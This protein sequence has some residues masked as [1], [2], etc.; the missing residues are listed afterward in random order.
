LC[1]SGNSLSAFEG[2]LDPTGFRDQLWNVFRIKVNAPQL[3]ALMAH[4][5]GDAS[6]AV[7]GS[8]FKL[9]FCRISAAAKEAMKIAQEQH[10][11]KV[12]EHYDKMEQKQ[13]EKFAKAPETKYDKNFTLVH[14]EKAITKVSK[15]PLSSSPLSLFLFLLFLLFL[16]L[17]FS[18]FSSF[19]SFS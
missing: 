13:I 3:G 1:S 14:Y 19:S 17:P 6:G 10:Q 2:I 11:K 7:D 12:K 8:E 15:Q 5:D 18:L 4:F 16:L 9:E